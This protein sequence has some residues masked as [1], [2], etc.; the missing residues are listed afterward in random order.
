MSLSNRQVSELDLSPQTVAA[1]LVATG[2]ELQS[3]DAAKQVWGL[4]ENRQPRARLVLPLDP[5]FVD[6]DQRFHEALNRLCMVFDWDVQQLLAGITS[7]RSDIRPAS[8]PSSG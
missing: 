2:W 4:T 5:E 6:F 8:R 3:E 1:F 7:V